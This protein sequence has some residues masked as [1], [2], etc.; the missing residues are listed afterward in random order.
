MINQGAYA[1]GSIR[2]LLP[3]A[4]N[5]KMKA[6]TIWQPWAMLI[7]LQEKGNET[8]GWPTTHR[9]PLAIHAAQY[10][11]R[12]A[13]ESEP[14]KTALATYGFTA[15]NLPLGTVLGT[16]NLADCW[17]IVG[18]D[19]LNQ[20]SVISDSAGERIYELS[21]DSQEYQVGDYSVGRYA[22]ELTDVR[23]F[24][25]PVP[26]KGKQKLWNWTGK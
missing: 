22:W 21:F 12:A 17:E 23:R 8:R 15:D 19:N 11:D 10:M 20:A 3:I 26:A 9:G 4:T 18:I 24:A 14:I 2:Q 25:E 5:Q 13:C 6:I 1:H 16:V 7:I